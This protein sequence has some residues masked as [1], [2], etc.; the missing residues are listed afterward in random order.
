MLRKRGL[1]NERRTSSVRRKR[2]KKRLLEK[3]QRE[4]DMTSGRPKRPLEKHVKMKSL[5]LSVRQNRMLDT[6]RQKKGSTQSK[7]QSSRECPQRICADRP[8]RQLHT[9]GLVGKSPRSPTPVYHC[10]RSVYEFAYFCLG[11]NTIPCD[12][13]KSFLKSRPATGRSRGTGQ[14]RAMGRSTL[15]AEQPLPDGYSY[16]YDRPDHYFGPNWL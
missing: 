9:Q 4:L 3:Q 2:L 16:N 10:T 15:T 8:C 12:S 1:Q 11:R 6:K 5:G 13:C 14:S 7:T